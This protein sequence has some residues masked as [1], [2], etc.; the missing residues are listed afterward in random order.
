MI[1]NFII[2][3]ATMVLRKSYD[4]DMTCIHNNIYVAENVSTF[5]NKHQATRRLVSKRCNE[6]EFVVKPLRMRIKMMYQ[7]IT[8]K[9]YHFRFIVAVVLFFNMSMF[10]DFFPTSMRVALGM[11]VHVSL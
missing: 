7:F 1:N 3:S 9:L 8:L 2:A 11:Y 5:Y 4:I 10:T 6:R